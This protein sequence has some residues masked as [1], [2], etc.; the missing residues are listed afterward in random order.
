MRQKIKWHE[1]HT[2]IASHYCYEIR[3][4]IK[5]IQVIGPSYNESVRVH[6]YNGN[7]DYWEFDLYTKDWKLTQT[8]KLEVSK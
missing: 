1:W 8:I 5:S 3:D 7:I 4:Q 6:W 2:D